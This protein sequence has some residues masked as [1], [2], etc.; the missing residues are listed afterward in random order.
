MQEK[1]LEQI[2][3]KNIVESG[4]GSGPC[5]SLGDKKKRYRRVGSRIM[6]GP[7]LKGHDE[8]VMSISRLVEESQSRDYSLLL[9]GAE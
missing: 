4:L 7:T 1:M 9:L 5:I 6:R 2:S 8:A 3:K